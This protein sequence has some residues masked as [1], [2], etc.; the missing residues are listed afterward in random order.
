MEPTTTAYI[1]DPTTTAY[2]MEPYTTDAHTMDPMTTAYIMDPTT[3]AYIME[4][5]TTDAPTM[6]PTTTAY[7]MEPTT[8]AYIMGPYTTDA[9]TMYSTTM[10]SDTIT[11]ALFNSSSIT[12]LLA[13]FTMEDV[14][15]ACIIYGDSSTYLAMAQ[16]PHLT[17]VSIQLSGANS[18]SVLA[19]IG[20]Y[21]TATQITV[22][23]PNTNNELP[24]PASFNSAYYYL[25]P[26]TS[27]TTLTYYMGNYTIMVFA[28]A[29]YLNDRKLNNADRIDINTGS[30]YT[31]I[32]SLALIPTSNITQ[33]P[34][35]P[36][37]FLEDAPVLTPR[38][39]EPIGSL[40]IGDI[41]ITTK[42][43]MAIVDVK[44][45]HVVPDEYSLPCIVPQGLYGATRRLLISQ[46]HQIRISS[47]VYKEARFLGLDLEPM[48]G[49][50]TYYN[51]ELADNT[52]D[53]IIA[54]VIVESW[55][56]W[57]GNERFA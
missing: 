39:Y 13:Q 36:A 44:V 45:Q 22:S 57:D 55:K 42:G 52:A 16:D 21:F 26:S 1:M 9:P 24:P 32:R 8:T 19:L 37:C 11:A 33:T 49:P 50:F 10:A 12:Q 38:G 43:P 28:G 47:G 53:M 25:I 20:N 7:I 40:A 6:D 34:S 4:P 5:Y 18:E 54:G 41:I 29:T 56:L 27:S 48:D 46:H 14:I 3:T 17:G 35:Q 2:I 23:I 30:Y 15:V 31:F 51:L